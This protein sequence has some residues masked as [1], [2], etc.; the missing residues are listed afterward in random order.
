MALPTTRHQ[1]MGGVLLGSMG[2]SL[3]GGLRG[4]KDGV[5]GLR[6]G[7]KGECEKSCSPF[8]FPVANTWH[9]W[10]KAYALYSPSPSEIDDNWRESGSVLPHRTGPLPPPSAPPQ[11]P[12]P[13]DTLCFMQG[14]SL[15]NDPLAG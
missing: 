1:A 9:S 6:R 10:H 12:L 14:S 11:K 5:G 3:Q 13:S 4:D 7:E 15:T 8:S 2:S